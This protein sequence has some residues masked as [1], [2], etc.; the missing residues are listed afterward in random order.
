MEAE[1][2]QRKG[3]IERLRAQVHKQE[4]AIREG[5]AERQDLL[6]KL[7]KITSENAYLTQHFHTIHGSAEHIAREKQEIAALYHPPVLTQTKKPSLIERLYPAREKPHAD[8][9]VD[10]DRPNNGSLP[11]L[12]NNA[13]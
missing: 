4:G 10:N 5:R 8:A 13:G 12:S 11:T 1:S 7:E 2:E 9:S 6:H 3:E